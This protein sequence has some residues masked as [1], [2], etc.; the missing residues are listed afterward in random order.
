MSFNENIKGKGW[1]DWALG[2]WVYF[3]VMVGCSAVVVVVW[4][5]FIGGFSW[6]FI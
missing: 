2:V 6:Y 3:P 1:S 4:S 5:D